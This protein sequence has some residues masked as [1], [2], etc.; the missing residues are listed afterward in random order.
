MTWKRHSTQKQNVI[1]ASRDQGYTVCP[2]SSDPPE[3]Y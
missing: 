2:G 3:K 1:M